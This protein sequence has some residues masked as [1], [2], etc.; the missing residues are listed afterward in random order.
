MNSSL[1]LFGLLGEENGLDVGEDASLSDGDSG[2]EF[3]EF[4][5]VPDGQL[6]VTGD[7]PGLLV[8]SGGVAGQLED[9]SGQVLHDGGQVDGGAGSHSLGVVALPQQTVDTTDGE[10]QT[11]SVG[12][13]LGL[14][15]DFASF[16]SSGHDDCL[17]VV[18]YTKIQ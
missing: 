4:L 15:L 5:V 11:S 10:L 9:L 6:Q 18:L 7:D 16:T 12:A 1:V 3:V 14:S 13:G 17:R 8:V 2:E